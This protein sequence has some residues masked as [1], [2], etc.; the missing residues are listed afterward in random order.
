MGQNDF[1]KMTDFFEKSTN[2]SVKPA[3]FQVS[4]FFLF[5]TRLNFVSV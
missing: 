4:I 5:L 2:N 1:Q 3:E